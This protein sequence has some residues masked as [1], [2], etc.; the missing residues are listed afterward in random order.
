N[1][2]GATSPGPIPGIDPTKPFSI[3]ANGVVASGTFNLTGAETQTL[4]QGNKSQAHNVQWRTDW[5][6]GG[7]L[8]G[9]LD[10][11]YARANSNLQAAAADVEHGYY[12]AFGQTVSAA[13]S[14]PGCNNFGAN[15]TTGNHGYEIQWSGGGSS[16]LPSAIALA[17]YA[18]VNS[19]PAYV[20]AKSNWA[21]ANLTRQEQE[22]VR[23]DLHYR[24]AFLNEASAVISAGFR[25]ANRDVDQTFGRYLIDGGAGVLGANNCCADPN[26]GSY[27]YYLDPGYVAI[28]Y[29]T[30]AS[31]PSLFKTVNNFGV[32]AIT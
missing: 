10:V 24:P 14:A 28:P 16:G 12:S 20:L 11:A 8:T 29:A 5:D 6:N 15:C 13:P 25:F 17:P 26:G 9:G 27:L 21:W 19:N 31:S 2:S 1:G 22:S 30:G 32:G 7:P 23:G 3:D 18:D 4:F